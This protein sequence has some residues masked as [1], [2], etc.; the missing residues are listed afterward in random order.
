VTCE[1]PFQYLEH[2]LS[3]PVRAGG[4]E[5]RFI[6]DTGIGV[7]LISESLAA[8]VGWSP[9][10]QAY[11]GRR[12]SGQPVTLPMGSLSSLQVGSRRSEDVPVGIF[13]MTPFAGLGDVQGFIS[14]TYFRTA[15]VTVDYRAGV[16]V[17]EDDAS[18]AGGAD[19]GTPVGVHVENDGPYSTG[20][21]LGVDLPGGRS[22]TVEVDTGSDAALI[23]DERFA[24]EA[25]I[26]LHA[27]GTR[28][29]EG[30]DETGHAFA[31]YFATLPGEIRL[32]QAPA[33]RLASPEVMVQ[34]IIYDGLMGN[35]FLR[36]YT[37]TYDLA[38]ARMIFA[39]PD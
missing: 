8:E 27:P 14:L 37:T 6:F 34:K 12:M 9:S 28:K 17:L 38:R 18:L 30:Q 13:D 19:R 16:I 21:H 5:T 20:V 33:F 7:S 26:D 25:G 32:T 15:P 35:R 31:R 10:G 24:A 39:S 1:V 3:I 22:I 2:L 36:N 29:I 11:T 23:M 4:I